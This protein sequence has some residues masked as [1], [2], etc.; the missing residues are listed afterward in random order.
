M[1]EPKQVQAFRYGRL[2]EDQSLSSLPQGRQRNLALLLGKNSD[3]TFTRLQPAAVLAVRPLVLLERLRVGTIAI[4]F[5]IPLVPSHKL[6]VPKLKD[7]RT[8]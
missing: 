8:L 2:Y 5:R 7:H 3:K 6:L 1:T 4:R